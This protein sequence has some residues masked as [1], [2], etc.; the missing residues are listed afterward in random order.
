M[1]VPTEVAK[2]HGLGLQSLIRHRTKLET[3]YDVA[4]HFPKKGIDGA[5]A[6]VGTWKGG[7]AYF[8][9]LALKRA[10]D[11]RPF[12]C[13]DTFAGLPKPSEKDSPKLWQGRWKADYG[14]IKKVLEGLRD[15]TQVIKGWFPKAFEPFS[16]M[17]FAFVHVDVDLYESVKACCEFFWPRLICE[18]SIIFD[19]YF[20]NACGGGQ[21]GR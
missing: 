18:G 4:S 6:E 8:I 15:E 14:Q 7:S 12:V 16:D 2:M 1:D 21:A 19:D 5:Y 20:A 10:G 13:C 9:S 11:S 17:R 3:I